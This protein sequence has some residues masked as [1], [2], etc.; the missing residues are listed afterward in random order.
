MSRR[1]AG[2][3]HEHAKAVAV[4]A[5]LIAH[6]LHHAEEHEDHRRRWRPA[7]GSTPEY[8]AAACHSIEPKIG[9]MITGVNN[10]IFASGDRT[11][12]RKP[13]SA[14]AETGSDTPGRCASSS[15]SPGFAGARRRCGDRGRRPAFAVR[16]LPLIQSDRRAVRPPE[17][18]R[19]DQRHS[20]QPQNRRHD[21]ALGRGHDAQRQ[22]ADRQDH[23][24]EPGRLLPAVRGFA[25]GL[26]RWRACALP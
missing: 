13:A 26:L 20:Q 18:G 3:Q 23:V 6:Q 25:V 12:E 2:R 17:T 16:G 10:I 8:R 4:E 9:I 1:D 11:S 19:S 5:E 7:A 24:H 15:R 21:V 22:P 14:T